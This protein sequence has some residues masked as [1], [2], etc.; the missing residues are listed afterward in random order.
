MRFDI[1]ASEKL[2]CLP[3]VANNVHGKDLPLIIRI[4]LRQATLLSSDHKASGQEQ[5]SQARSLKGTNSYSE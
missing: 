5:A 1:A 3:L 4:L 2:L